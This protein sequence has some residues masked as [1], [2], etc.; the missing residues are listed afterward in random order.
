M[1]KNNINLDPLYRY[2]LLKI[3]SKAWNINE[4]ILSE[5]QLS[6]KFSLSRADV[7]KVLTNLCEH[8][9]L[10]KTKGYGYYVT[11]N[12]RFGLIDNLMEHNEY[13]CVSEWIFFSKTF[14][15]LDNENFKKVTADTNFYGKS[16]SRVLRAIYYD[17]ENKA[18]LLITSLVNQDIIK[19]LPK[20]LL[21]LKTYEL[22]ALNGYPIVYENEILALINKPSLK[23]K[24]TKSSTKH[25]DE[26][27]ICSYRAC[28][29]FDKKLVALSKIV[30]LNENTQLKIVK[31]FHSLKALIS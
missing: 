21:D 6:L 24:K 13:R 23:E 11:E 18:H 26:K 16:F 14:N 8:G 2:I 19:L 25:N 7:R 5:R 22:F 28:F 9:I 30:Y 10:S 20:K 3:Q 4:K 17:K 31:G 27:V 1:L 15:E 29:S 12:C